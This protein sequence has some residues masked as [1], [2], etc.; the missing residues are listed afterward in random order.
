MI[1]DYSEYVLESA[2]SGLVNFVDQENNAALFKHN[3]ICPF[4]KIKIKIFS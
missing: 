2:S 3:S 4:C 1:L